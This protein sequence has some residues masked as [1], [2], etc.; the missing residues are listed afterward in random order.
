MEEL[1]GTIPHSEEVH[2]FLEHEDCHPEPPARGEV[3]IFLR[4]T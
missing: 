2:Q 1:V 3:V 4:R